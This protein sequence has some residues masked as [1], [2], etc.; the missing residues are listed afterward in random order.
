MMMILKGHVQREGLALGPET[1]EARRDRTSPTAKVQVGRVFD[2]MF[3]LM[4]PWRI[5]GSRQFVESGPGPAG[6]DLI[7]PP[8][9]KTFELSSRRGCKKT[10]PHRRDRAEADGGRGGAPAGR[11]TRGKSPASAA[12]Q[13][14]EQLSEADARVL[15]WARG[16]LCA[17]YLNQKLRLMNEAEIKV[18]G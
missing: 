11:G 8:K 4:E 3:K 7:T 5:N 16:S 18:S 14:D 17:G 10:R 12:A 13:R 6:T 1:G 9:F 2:R 15:R